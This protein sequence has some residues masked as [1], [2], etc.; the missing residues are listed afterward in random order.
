MKNVYYRLAAALIR[1]IRA[2]F[3]H[4]AGLVTVHSP[5]AN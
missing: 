3:T 4:S 5:H 2:R 1:R